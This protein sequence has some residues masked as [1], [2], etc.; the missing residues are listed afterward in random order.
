MTALRRSA[1]ALALGGALVACGSATGG[2]T[3]S[4]R[5]TTAA[6]APPA[7]EQ[8][9]RALV[10]LATERVAAADAVAA[11][12]WGTDRPVDDPVREKALLD[13]VDAQ[14]AREGVDQDVVRRVFEDRIEADK[15]VRRALR[16][17]WEEDPELLPARRPAPADRTR[18]V[19]DPSD[20]RLL[21]AVRGAVSLLSGP[22]CETV[23][24]RDK[25]LVARSAGLDA[26]HGDGLDRALAHACG[27]S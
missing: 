12:E 8:A 23:L 15:E 3:G 10:R 21:A 4:A 11:A 22:R 6:A 25:A 26:V 5:P 9:V 19:P 14:A 16:E 1:V 20:Q 17:R 18:P 7:A 24:D 2:E 27:S 13:A